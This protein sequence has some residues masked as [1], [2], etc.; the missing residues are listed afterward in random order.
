MTTLSITR[1]EPERHLRLAAEASGCEGYRADAVPLAVMDGTALLAVVVLDNFGPMGADLH[2]ATFDPRWRARRA[3]AMLY[4]VVLSPF[5]H[6][7][8]LPFVRA[9]IP[10]GNVETQIV[11]LKTGYTFLARFPA[12]TERPFDAIVMGMAAEDCRW[13]RPAGPAPKSDDRET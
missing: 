1:R 11:A 7:F 2:L 5:P 8:G 13:L 3:L 12:G 4:R 9:V 6:G 10:E